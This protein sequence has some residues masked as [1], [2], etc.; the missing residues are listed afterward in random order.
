MSHPEPQPAFYRPFIIS[1]PSQHRSSI[2]QQIPKISASM[3]IE[4][5]KWMEDALQLPLQ[6]RDVT[7]GGDEY[8][9]KITRESDDAASMFSHSTR[10]T[11]IYHNDSSLTSQPAQHQPGHFTPLQRERYRTVTLEHSNDLSITDAH[12]SASS[13]SNSQK[14]GI[15]SLG[16]G[17]FHRGHR[18]WHSSQSS[19]VVQSPTSPAAT[20]TSVHQLSPSRGDRKDLAP[21]GKSTYSPSHYSGQSNVAPLTRPL[22]SHLHPI[23]PTTAAPS[24]PPPAATSLGQKIIKSF[25]SSRSTSNHHQPSPPL[26]TT[27]NSST[28]TTTSSSSS[29][30]LLTKTRPFSDINSDQPPPGSSTHSRRHIAGMQQESGRTMLQGSSLSSLTDSDSDQ[31]L[32]DKLSPLPA[33]S[34]NNHST[35]NVSNQLAGTPLEEDQNTSTDRSRRKSLPMG[36]NIQVSRHVRSASDDDGKSR[37]SSKQQPKLFDFLV[38]VSLVTSSPDMDTIHAFH[39]SAATLAANT[40]P[41][42]TPQIT[43]KY[44]GSS[45][46]SQSNHADTL[47][48]S[49]KQLPSSPLKSVNDLGAPET[50]TIP[51]ST[52]TASAPVFTS[53]S[54]HLL[55]NISL[56]CFPEWH[57]DTT[58]LQYL[59]EDILDDSLQSE[60]FSFILTDVDGSKRFGYCR[61]ISSQLSIAGDIPVRVPLRVESAQSRSS[62]EFKIKRRCLT[63]DSRG[64]RCVAA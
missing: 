28:T 61:R 40:S 57:A 43:F 60:T 52:P 42:L 37:N 2:N 25:Q 41:L 44:D 46:I 22:P 50:P 63:R 23:N 53:T 59:K 9:V 4:G 55:D 6:R 31:P 11:S 26:K 30:F 34:A 58:V 54:N 35:A 5:N 62:G 10:R 45:P 51:S 12:N 1:G 15:T 19:A 47:P 18:R 29:L 7:I 20:A 33:F 17:E 38:V 27:T 48:R 39:P 24:A 14:N 21:I 8:A 56:F 36:D 32:A 16:S 49:R 3:L 13:S 64:S